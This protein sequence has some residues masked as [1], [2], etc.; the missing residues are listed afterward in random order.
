MPESELP[1][2]DQKVFGD[3]FAA[4]PQV[5]QECYHKP[6][7]QKVLDTHANKIYVSAG[8]EFKKRTGNTIDDDD[9]HAIIKTTF[10]CLTKIDESRAVR[11]RMTLEE[12]TWI[13]N[14]PHLTVQVVSDAIAVFREAGNTFVKPF[15]SEEESSSLA[16]D[17]VLDITHESLIRNWEMLGVWA[18]EEYDKFMILKDF[19]QQVDRWLE[20][21]KSW[22]FLLPIGSLTYFENWFQTTNPNPHWVNRYNE[23][24]TETAKNLDEST[25]IV[26]NNKDY[27][28]RSGQKHAI[29]RAVLK[30]GPKKIGLGL[31]IILLLFTT[32]FVAYDFIKE[33]NGYV[34]RQAIDQGERILETDLANLG[35]RASYLVNRERMNKGDAFEIINKISDPMDRLTLATSTAYLVNFYNRKAGGND[36]VFES[37]LFASDAAK[38]LFE[39]VKSGQVSKAKYMAVLL[40]LIDVADQ[41]C[42]FNNR[43][44]I[45]QESDELSSLLGQLVSSTIRNPNSDINVKELNEALEITLNHHALSNEEIQNLVKILSP[46][47]NAAGEFPINAFY[48]RNKSIQVGVNQDKFTYNGLYQILGELYASMGD[49][50]S[51]KRA[52]DTLIRYHP[53]YED[54]STDGYSI[55]GYFASYNHWQ[56][57]DAYAG[58]VAPLFNIKPY[59]VYQ[60]TADRLGLSSPPMQLRYAVTR[61]IFANVWANPILDRMSI[62]VQDQF[63]KQYHKHLISG[64]YGKDETSFALALFYKQQGAFVSTRNQNRSNQESTKLV[65]SLFAASYGS[66][67]Q[68]SEAYKSEPVQTFLEAREDVPR[69]QLYLYPDYRRVSRHY[70][71]RALFANYN[72]GAFLEF[73]FDNDLFND[74][75]NSRERLQLAVRWISEYKNAFWNDAFNFYMANDVSLATLEKLRESILTH[76]DGENLN[77]TLLDFL[78]AERYYSLGMSSKASQLAKKIQ[79][80]QIP[81]LLQE[82]HPLMTSESFDLIKKVYEQLVLHNEY[83]SASNI[84][85]G[86]TNG[87]NKIRLYDGAAIKLFKNGQPDLGMIFLDSAKEINEQIIVSD[88]EFFDYEPYHAFALFMSNDEENIQMGL[89]EITVLNSFFRIEFGYR[90]YAHA[91]AF[92]KQYYEALLGNKQRSP[93]EELIRINALLQEQLED[94]DTVWKNFELNS[95]AFYLFTGFSFGG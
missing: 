56:A 4:L 55:A 78:L 39:Q 16:P 6:G 28:K 46:F 61:S 69:S 89:R 65:D 38:E 76:K 47:E 92:N 90:L 82:R 9:A 10:T 37:I 19:K 77:I 22:G 93:E 14:K 32:S 17:T 18:K 30:F 63:Y 29:A 27:L 91:M 48:A 8:Y 33:Q 81:G 41:N 60:R 50:V 1:E 20:H 15:L 71:P 53:S 40:E 75:F 83:S 25:Q 21:D 67:Q 31:A 52:V 79:P 36:F 49:A 54:Y 45:A 12:I 13:L 35:T 70:E 23:L 68:V 58:M 11:N 95:D 73:I 62:A 84:M 66:Y 94:D 57:L 86:F 87:E 72:S 42:S 74:F 85:S 5:I 3:W 7:L 51:A 2:E 59:E 44:D 43:E 34:L 88:G 64:N 26:Q 24:V 80:I